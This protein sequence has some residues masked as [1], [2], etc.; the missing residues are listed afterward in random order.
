MSTAELRLVVGLV[1]V[2]APALHILSIR[3]IAFIGMGIAVLVCAG[4]PDKVA[5]SGPGGADVAAC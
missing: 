3:N 4:G 5:R 2:I 1:A